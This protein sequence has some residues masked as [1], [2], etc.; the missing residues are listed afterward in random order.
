MKILDFVTGGG[1]FE[2]TL[3]NLGQQHPKAKFEELSTI[4]K[5]DKEEYPD[6][7]RIYLIYS[8]EWDQKAVDSFLLESCNLIVSDWF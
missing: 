4:N 7:V 3:F 6:Y 1:D 5:D 2:E 8:G